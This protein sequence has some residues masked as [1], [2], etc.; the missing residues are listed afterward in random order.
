MEPG[1]TH[2]TLSSLFEISNFC[3]HDIICGLKESCCD[4]ICGSQASC[5]D[6][7]SPASACS[8]N[9]SWLPPFK[10]LPL[11]YQNHVCKSELYGTCIWSS[12]FKWCIYCSVVQ[13]CSSLKWDILFLYFRTHILNAHV[14]CIVSILIL[15]SLLSE[16]FWH[17]NF[18]KQVHNYYSFHQGFKLTTTVWLCWMLFYIV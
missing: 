6:M 17:A 7:I 13:P 4:M 11:Q 1:S 8:L 3:C 5:H 2:V 14:L 10:F 9:C 16:G 18:P 15:V 12:S